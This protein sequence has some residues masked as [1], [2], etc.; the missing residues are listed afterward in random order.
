VRY[1]IPGGR[2]R[3]HPD[4]AVG[5]VD[6]IA[7]DVICEGI[8]STAT[9]EIEPG[10]V[11]VAGQDAILDASPV[12]RKT[13]VGTPVVHR[14]QLSVVV[15]HRDGVTAAGDHRATAR[16]DFLYGSHFYLPGYCRTQHDTS[17]EVW[18]DLGSGEIGYLRRDYGERYISLR[19]PTAKTVILWFS[20]SRE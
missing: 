7:A 18:G 6:G 12:Q 15:K 8:E 19:C 4:Y 9:G 16:L 1:F 13:H 2:L 5:D 10:V 20:L 11:P 3:V 17:L 14:E